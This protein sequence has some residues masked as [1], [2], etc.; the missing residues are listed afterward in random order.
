MVKTSKCYNFKLTRQERKDL[1][2]NK[3]KD[4]KLDYNKSICDSYIK[5]GTSELEDVVDELYR[6][7]TERNNKLCSLLDEL[8]NRNLEYDDKVPSYKKFLKSGGNLDKTIENGELEKVL[9]AETDYLSIAGDINS[10]VAKEISLNAF[11]KKGKK[12]K[13]VDKYVKNKNTLKF[14]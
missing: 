5:F 4:M 8:R 9:I 10:E 7:Q 1:L 14:E 3:L 11:Y 6:K 2:M 12:S 13:V